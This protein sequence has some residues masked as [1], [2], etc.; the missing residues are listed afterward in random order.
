MIVF[1][2][3]FF[4]ALRVLAHRRVPHGRRNAA[5]LAAHRRIRR[6]DRGFRVR[7]PRDRIPPERLH[8]DRR[9][10]DQVLV[11]VRRSMK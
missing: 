5:E 1:A 6:G 4:L 10:Y 2:L 3:L 7:R 11:D 9:L 8:P